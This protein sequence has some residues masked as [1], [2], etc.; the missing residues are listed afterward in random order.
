MPD[1]LRITE[2]LKGSFTGDLRFDALTRAMYAS[3]ASLYEVMPLG[4][5]YPRHR[6]DVVAL[7]K[8]CAEHAIPLIARGAGTNVTGGALGE[9]IIVD[10]SRHFTAIKE[11]TDQSVRVQAGVVRDTLNKKLRE[12]GRYLPPD[13]STTAVTTV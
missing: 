5:A 11:I 4:V 3:D 2:D 7:S 10:L 6:D 1:P 12:V 8:Y 13:P 9:G